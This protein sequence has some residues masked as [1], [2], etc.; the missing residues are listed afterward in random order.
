[1][2]VV[3]VR[4][5]TCRRLGLLHDAGDPDGP[6]VVRG[7]RRAGAIDDVPVHLID[8]LLVPNEV[9]L[10]PALNIHISMIMLFVSLSLS[11]SLL[12]SLV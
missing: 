3:L 12:L 4:I 1:M 5:F 7:V 11:S 9:E 10:V 8:D 2:Y 6:P